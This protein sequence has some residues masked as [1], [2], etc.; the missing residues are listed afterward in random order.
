MQDLLS[1]A[2]CWGFAR[3]FFRVALSE[4]KTSFH[5]FAK[6]PEIASILIAFKYSRSIFNARN[7]G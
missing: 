5:Y 3:G 1:F 7:G 4:H 6:S 2:F